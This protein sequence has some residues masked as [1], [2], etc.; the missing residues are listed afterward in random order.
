VQLAA[1]LL[2]NNI[3]FVDRVFELYE[4]RKWWI[5]SH[6]ASYAGVINR[7]HVLDFF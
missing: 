2:L 5:M 7:Q 4:L 6:K 1:M 3:K